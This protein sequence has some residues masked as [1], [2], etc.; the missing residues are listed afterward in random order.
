MEKTALSPLVDWESFYVIVGS[1][2]AVLIG[3]QFVAV[4][5]SAEINVRGSGA[6]V[7]AFSTPTIVHFSAALFV[8]AIL[9]APW[10]AL[11]GAGLALGVCA[12]VGLVYAAI[13]VLRARRQTDYVPVLED[14]VWHNVL[15]FIAYAALLVAAIL[16]QSYPAPSLFVV[17]G[18]ALLLL[19]VGIHNAWDSVVYI[20]FRRRQPEQGAQPEEA[21]PEPEQASKDR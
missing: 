5:M 1:S 11:S 8:A 21:E 4:T 6:V 18:T 7:D 16:L 19:F 17:A 3:L 13:I 12:V 20:A 2:A 10:P 9:S 14:W 15:P